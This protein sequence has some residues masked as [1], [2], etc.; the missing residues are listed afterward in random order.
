MNSLLKLRFKSPLDFES[1]IDQ[2]LSKNFPIYKEFFGSNF[3][4][5]G[6]YPRLDI[7]DYP[8]KAVIIA[9]IPGLTKEDITIDYKDN[10]LTISGKKREQKEDNNEKYE[11]IVKEI[12]YSS[13][14]RKIT[15]GDNYDTNQIKAKYDG[16]YLEITIPKKEPIKKVKNI[17]IE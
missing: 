4:A 1:A 14:C 12:K 9:E 17:L 16:L 2:F 7:R 10:V 13:F 8:D 3:F 6:A 15:I 5:D 11:V